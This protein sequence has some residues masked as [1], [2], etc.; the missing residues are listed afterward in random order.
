MFNVA[1]PLKQEFQVD[2]NN[3]LLSELSDSTG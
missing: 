1:V 2:I 3:F